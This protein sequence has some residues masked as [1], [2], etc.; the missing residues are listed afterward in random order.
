MNCKFSLKQNNMN[1]KFSLE[2]KSIEQGFRTATFIAQSNDNKEIINA[3]G[4]MAKVLMPALG[5][6]NAIIHC[7]PSNEYNDVWISIPY[8]NT[9]ESIVLKDL[10]YILQQNLFE[11][12][13]K[14]L[15]VKCDV[16]NDY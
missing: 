5:F 14:Y 10:P 16:D 4:G 6:N 7:Y 2:Q 11:T 15:G 1:C 13:C 12:Y 3:G 9:I 8:R